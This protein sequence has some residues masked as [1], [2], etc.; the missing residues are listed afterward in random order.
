MAVELLPNVRGPLIVEGTVRLGY[1][2][3]LGH[4]GLQGLGVQP[5]P[6]WGLMVSENQAL[7]TT[8]PGPFCF[9]QPA[10][11]GSWSPSGWPPTG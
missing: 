11:P 4:A 1:R 9:Q 10:S 8:A 6:D 7:L 5:H 3:H 2:L